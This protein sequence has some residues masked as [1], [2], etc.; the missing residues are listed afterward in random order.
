MLRNQGYTLGIFERAYVC[1]C[2]FSLYL[3]RDD[4][5]IGDRSCCYVSW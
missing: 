1:I 2:Y 3:F 5:R 4:T